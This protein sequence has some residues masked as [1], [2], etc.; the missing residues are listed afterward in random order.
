M[1]TATK[2]R[3]KMIRS[4]KRRRRRR[5]MRIHRKL[6]IVLGNGSTGTCILLRWVAL[7]YE[8]MH[9]YQNGVQFTQKISC[10]P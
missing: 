9:C 4:T 5:K 1:V 7:A 6:L 10:T 3:T 8:Y 2:K